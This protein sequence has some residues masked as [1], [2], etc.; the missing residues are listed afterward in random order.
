[1]NAA[2]WYTSRATGLASLVM[3]T[4]VL[5]LGALN[6]ARFA[7]R[8]W[9]RFTVADLHRNLSLITV[10]FL[11][12]HIVTAILDPFAG[13]GWLSILVPFISTY[14][15]FWLGLGAVALDLLLALLVS[16]LLRPRIKPQVWRAIHW[17]AYACWPIAVLHG[18]GIGGADS[19]QAWVLIL[20]GV[21]VLAAALAVAWRANV[22]HPDT[23]ARRR[24]WSGVR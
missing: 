20:T 12:V 19:R 8:N 1:M 16:S 3:L 7:T 15:P 14:Y 5:V 10:A 22:R 4:G 23:E 11:A 9:P 6:S 13:I 21:C 24:P 18:W 17:A 2:L